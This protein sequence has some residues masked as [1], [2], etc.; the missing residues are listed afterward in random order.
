MSNFVTWI[1]LLKY[2][3]LHQPDQT[4]YLFLQDGEQET[5]KLS[6]QQLDV[7]ACA[8]AAQLQSLEVTGERAL[9]LYPS[10]LEFIAAFFGCLYAGVIAVPAYPPRPNQKMTRLSAIVTDAEAKILLT[11]A[12]LLQSI[13]SRFAQAS[14]LASLHAFATD[15]IPSN[16]ASKWQEPDVNRET[17]AFLQYTSGSTGT[18]KGVMVSH[19]NLLHNCEYMR[20]AFDLTPDSVSV[21]WLPSFHDMGLILGI[22]EPLYVGFPAILM[23][24]TAFAQQPIRWLQTISRYKATHSGGPNFAYELCTN[25]IT[26]EQLTTLDLSS[27]RCAFNGAEPVRRQT[28]EDFAAKFKPYGF[29]SNQ[30]YPCYGMAEATL[31]ISGGLVDAEP[32]YDLVEANTLEQ[33]QIVTAASNTQSVK[34]LVGCG[35]AWLDAKIV[36]A[37][38][39]SL[40]QCHPNQVGEIWISGRSVTQGYWRRPEQTKHTFEARLQDTQEGPF[41]R[42]GDLG[43][44]QNGELFITGRLK[45]I[46]IIRGRNHYPQDIELTVQQCHPALR[47]DCGAAFAVEIAGED[48]LVVVQEV[49]R[50]ALRQL[51]LDAIGGAIRR[52]ISEEHELQVYAIALLKP[53]SILKTSSGKIQRHACRNGFLTGTLNVVGE[54]QQTLEESQPSAV[55]AQTHGHKQR[56]LPQTRTE[57]MI[58]AWL[59]AKLSTLLSIAPQEI[60]IQQS[61][62]QYG[63][64]S[65]S[66]VTLAGELEQWLGCK[67]SSTAVYEY[68]SIVAL[69]HYLAN[70]PLTDVQLPSCLV[71][72]QL[73]GT[74]PPFFC[75]HPLAGVIFPYYPLMHLFDSE[76]PFWALQ[77]VGIDEQ[78]QPLTQIEAMAAHYTEAL[79]RVQPQGPYYIGGWSFG[80]YVALE[81]ATQLKQQGQEVAKVVL[82]DTPPLSANK[83][84]NLFEL[85]T[86][87]LTSSAP[88]IWPYVYDYLQLRFS[89]NQSQQEVD[90]W[91]FISLLNPR[92]IA[93]TIEQE[94]RLI[95]FR[96]PILQ[97]M[98]Q[99]IK[100]NS[101]ALI[102]YQP[103]VYPG[104]ITLFHADPLF[105]NHGQASITGWLNLAVQGAEVH[106]IP[107][108]HFS[109]LRS[110]HVE[111]LARKLSACLDE[112]P[113]Q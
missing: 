106:Q 8:I 27:W 92:S 65:L 96:Q 61:M 38:P 105:G 45:D 49:H 111:V 103:K 58:Q 89:G 97:R 2:R 15:T 62:T 80:A 3:A 104:K 102:N 110:P 46:V 59:V 47:P 30:L 4:A 21:S 42:T 78:E 33:N 85:L 55:S 31:M 22:L 19:D 64:D 101:E 63:L 44:L 107:G 74:K 87:F 73:Q 36:I 39:E 100:A 34:H 24:P 26:P 18:P 82:L 93:K 1:E 108:H 10:G 67:L 50:Q 25:K 99:V 81:I 28:L 7:L 66:M 88:H 69:A 72:L 86:F 91:H 23:P 98:V 41:L 83:I 40:V 71:P 109:L 14:E 90:L 13:E 94:S 75:V 29:H 57:S 5:S 77:S 43:F 51:D 12:S 84:S 60:D 35:Q 48:R 20:Q 16:Q 37:D 11:T 76:R 9:L 56:S 70:P 112:V 54:W 68:P 17:L 79:R 6:Y 95:A 113:S 52:A 53:A 32:I